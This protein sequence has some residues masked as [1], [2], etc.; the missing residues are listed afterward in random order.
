MNLLDIIII[1]VMVF[2]LVK[3]LLIGFFR[4]VAFLAGIILGIWLGIRFMPEL[5]SMIKTQFDSVPLLPLISFA[6]IFLSTLIVCY[7]LG[8]GLSLLL[9]KVKLKWIDRGLGAGLAIVQ[10]IILTYLVIIILT[11]FTPFKTPSLLS[12]SK[13]APYVTSSYQAIVQII[14]PEHYK[15]LKDRLLKNKGIAGK[16]VSEQLK[17]G[18]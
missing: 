15:A 1:V 12:D 9:K 11:F 17:D 13:L 5:S 7:I 2:F 3:G 18:I 4:E 14:S 10:G 8:W 6:V 16:I